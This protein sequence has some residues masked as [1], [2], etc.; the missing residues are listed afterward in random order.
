MHHHQSEKEVK[1]KQQQKI[2]YLSLPKMC[3]LY[4]II[5]ITSESLKYFKQGKICQ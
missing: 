3:F 1:R 4:I 2:L 5:I